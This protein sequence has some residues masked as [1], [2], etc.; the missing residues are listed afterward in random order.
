MIHPQQ[1]DNALGAS[2]SA[3]PS[4]APGSGSP[5]IDLKSGIKLEHILLKQFDFASQTA[6]A[7]RQDASQMIYFYW[8]MF[9]VLVAGLGFL[10]Q[11]G[12]AT[13]GQSSAGGLASYTQVLMLVALLGAGTVHLAFYS[14]W[15]RLRRRFTDCFAFM[16]GISAFYIQ[17]FEHDIPE[18][19]TLLAWQPESA[20]ATAPLS[21]SLFTVYSLL[22]ALSSLF[23]GAAVVVGGEVWLQV[24]GGALLPLPV[25]LPLYSAAGAVVVVSC[26]LFWLT[27]RSMR[28]SGKTR[29]PVLGDI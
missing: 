11:L 21:D 3:M 10:L 25:S 22:P 29:I 27:R 12:G 17:R 1:I 19:A 16:T 14:R 4:A 5:D 6:Q 20:G 18:I 15:L 23:F 28:S 2:S 9:G 26:A 8:V 24:N 7:V 13:P